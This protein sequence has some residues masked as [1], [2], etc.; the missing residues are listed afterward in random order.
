MV[1]KSDLTR[2]PQT[3]NKFTGTFIA[4]VAFATFFTLIS[5]GT[6][7]FRQPQSSAKVLR[8]I[9]QLYIS[10]TPSILIPTII[11]SKVE[12]EGE[13]ISDFPQI[14][15]YFNATLVNTYKK[16]ENDKTGYEA[17]WNTDDTVYSVMQWY[18]NN[19]ENDGWLTLELPQNQDSDAEQF[20]IFLRKGKTLYLTVENEDGVLTEIHAEF[21]LSLSQ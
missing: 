3:D 17:N 20:A 11:H 19:L 6:Y 7:L 14:P 15:V 4:L 16:T 8:P 12:K 13:F 5:G 9:V 21:P 18:I 2:N 1:H 10:P